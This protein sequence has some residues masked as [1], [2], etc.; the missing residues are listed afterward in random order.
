MLDATEESGKFS[1]DL[2]M[3][4]QIRQCPHVTVSVTVAVRTSAPLTPETV[5]VKA[6]RGV[7]DVVF[8]DIFDEPGATTE[9]GLKI[10]VAPAGVPDTDSD[11]VPEKPR[12]DEMDTV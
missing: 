10:T 2:S 3:S 4:F 12:S 1:L 8:T 7:F 6:P 11:T 5:S 9:V